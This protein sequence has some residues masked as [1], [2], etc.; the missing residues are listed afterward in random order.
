MLNR[1]GQKEA[2]CWEVLPYFVHTAEQ[3]EGFPPVPGW[4]W[5][6]ALAAVSGK[7]AYD[8]EVTAGA[9]RAFLREAEAGDGQAMHSLGV[10]DEV[11]GAWEEA[12]SWF[13]RAADTGRAESAG[14]V[15][16]LLV[17]RGE[18]KEAERY[19]ELAAEAGDH[20]AATL[21][22]K[23][24]RDRAAK[25]FGAAA[26]SGNPE[27]AH[28]LG[29]LLLA[30]GD[31]DGAG[32]CYLAAERQGYAEVARSAGVFH[33]VMSE[34]ETAR[35][36]LT[37]AAEAGDARAAALVTE[38]YKGPLSLDDVEGYFASTAVYPLDNT[39]R[40]VVLE[41]R[42]RVALARAYYEK[43][44]E[45]GDSYGAY[46]LA[47]LLEKQGKPEEATTWYR[48]AA[49]MGHHAARKALAERPTTPDTVKE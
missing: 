10:L 29:D 18:N 7:P 32:D 12:E 3:D 33:L 27:A 11:L 49:A 23:V 31:F 47:A 26:E 15:G 24:L 46:R 4:V 13:R 40:G 28:R 43:G 37:R 35:V 22:G 20:E 39:H 30:D 8:G 48:K 5:R 16:R 36:W 6:H 17:E 2:S 38:T 44:Y 42:R 34:H 41:K 14:H 45:A 25:W 19:L 21:L 9:R 1:S